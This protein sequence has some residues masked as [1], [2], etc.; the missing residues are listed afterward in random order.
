MHLGKRFFCQDNM[1]PVVTHYK[2]I[3]YLTTSSNCYI[4]VK[5]AFFFTESFKHPFFYIKI[6]LILRYGI[7]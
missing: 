2:N 5:L 6:T 4:A 1:S 3:L 7:F